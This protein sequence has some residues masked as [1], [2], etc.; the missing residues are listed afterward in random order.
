M[1]HSMHAIIMA[2]GS[3]TRFWPMSR[4]LRP[5]QLLA[6]FGEQTMMAQTAERLR[7][8]TGDEG[9]LI[10][11]GAHL[12]DGIQ[13]ALP[14]LPA[15]NIIAEPVGRNTAPCIGLATHLIEHR[16]GQGEDPI[17]GVFAADHHVADPEGFRAAVAVAVEAASEPGV[18]VTLGI[19]PTR[20]E[21]GYGYIQ[22]Q[23]EGEQGGAYPVNRFV[24]KPDRATAER[25]LASGDHLWNAGLF[26]FRASTMRQEIARQLPRMAERLDAIAAAFDD[27]DGGQSALARIFP[28]LESISIDYGVMEDA[29]HVKVVPADVG[30]NDVGH[31]AALPGL[32]EADDDGNILRGDVIARDTR[33]TAAFNDR[34]D[35]L[36]AVV[37][38]DDLVVVTTEDA[39][40]VVPRER[41]QQVRDIVKALKEAHR[42]ELL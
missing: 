31:W 3:G 30:W 14:S 36:L 34:T 40:L 17:I 5:K 23:P 22:Y 8:L 37:G 35:H 12:V 9:M 1:T 29:A 13:A 28:T 20:P 10:V 27:E 38:V 4:R 33:H 24:E 39:T 26:F 6:L 21:T 11:T 25:Y 16:A 41:A 18:I 32:L 15:E 19:A 2:G 42:D 7:P